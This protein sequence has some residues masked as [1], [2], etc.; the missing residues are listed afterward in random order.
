MAAGFF[1]MS[2]AERNLW[3]AEYMEMANKNDRLAMLRT[4]HFNALFEGV[5]VPITVSPFIAVVRKP[6][7][8]GLSE[9]YANN[10]LWLI[11]Q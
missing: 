1:G 7:R 6:W 3:L 9:L 10:Q 5:L 4:V 11:R 8:M 2:K